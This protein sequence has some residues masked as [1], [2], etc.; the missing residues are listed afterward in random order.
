MID[1]FVGGLPSAAPPS[2]T[3]IRSSETDDA[4]S[5]FYIQFIFELIRAIPLL[6]E[7]DLRRD[8]IE[9]CKF[10]FE[11][12]GPNSRLLRS[13]ERDRLPQ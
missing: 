1:S 9:W 3:E 10:V 12:K 4:K 8:F 6:V 5:L 2:A 11:A 13:E 7:L